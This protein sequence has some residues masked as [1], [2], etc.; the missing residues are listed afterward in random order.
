MRLSLKYEIKMKKNEPLN[1]LDVGILATEIC[2]I[3]KILCHIGVSVDREK[4][5]K[6]RLWKD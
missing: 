6:L 1:V 2:R 5:Q 4:L 3:E